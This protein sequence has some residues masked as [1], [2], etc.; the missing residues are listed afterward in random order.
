MFSWRYGSEE[1]GIDIEMGDWSGTGQEKTNT[2]T[3]FCRMA[4]RS[5]DPEGYENLIH[6][7]FAVHDEV[8]ARNL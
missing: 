6:I 8:T 3:A 4:K 7:E 1:A 5:L 2:H